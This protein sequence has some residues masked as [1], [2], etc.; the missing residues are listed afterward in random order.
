MVQAAP[1]YPPRST[2]QEILEEKQARL[3]HA[4]DVLPRCR[5]IVEIV[6]ASVDKGIFPNDSNVREVLHVIM[7]EAR[8]ALMMSRRQRRRTGAKEL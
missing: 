4:H 7:T 3:D 5:C 1:R 2:H 6:H 8:E